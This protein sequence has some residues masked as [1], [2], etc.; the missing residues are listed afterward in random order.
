MQLLAN[1]TAILHLAYFAFVVLGSLAITVGARRWR[2]VRNSWFR[3]LHLLAIWAVLAEDMIGLVCPLNV[4]ETHFR[5]AARS[6]E[7]RFS[8][9]LDRLL[10]HT[11]HGRPLDIVYW[12]L[13]AASLVLL[14]L[15]PPNFL[16]RRLCR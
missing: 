14:F 5:G 1:L 15:V 2:W 6:R 4:A 12:S 3:A 11:L 8:E 7:T 16:S 9:I 13:G 10:H